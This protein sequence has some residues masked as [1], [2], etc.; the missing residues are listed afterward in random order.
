LEIPE[1]EQSRNRVDLPM[2]LKA[3]VKGKNLDLILNF[4]RN[5]F[6]VTEHT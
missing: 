5:R 1:K 2:D 3:F 4:K 6:P